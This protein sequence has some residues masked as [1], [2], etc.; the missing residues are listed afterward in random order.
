MDWTK[1]TKEDLQEARTQSFGAL[2]NADMFHAL[3]ASILEMRSIQKQ[4]VQVEFNDPVENDTTN[5]EDIDIGDE[6]KLHCEERIKAMLQEATRT[7]MML[8]KSYYMDH[9]AKTTM[10]TFP[11]DSSY[12]IEEN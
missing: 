4:L 3:E 9:L 10:V 5:F 2:K 7:H 6:T 1:T 8:A 12:D 11:V